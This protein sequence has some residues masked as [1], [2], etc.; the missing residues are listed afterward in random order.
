MRIR[1]VVLASTL[2]LLVVSAEAAGLIARGEGFGGA[3]SA[4]ASGAEGMW[5]NPAVL[6]SQLVFSANAG[7]GLEGGNNALSIMDVARLAATPSSAKTDVVKKIPAAGWDADIRGAGGAAV[8]LSLPV[9]G[10]FGLGV[11]E[12]QIVTAEKISK[13]A[14][15]FALNYSPGNPNASYPPSGK[16]YTAN[17]TYDFTG[18][19]VS[20]SVAEIGLGYSKDVPEPVPGLGLS[21]GASVKYLHGLAYNDASLDQHVTFNSTAPVTGAGVTYRESSKGSGIGVDIGAHAKLFG[22]A[23][24]AIVLKNIG[25]KMTWKTNA[26]AGSLNVN[27]MGFT[28]T[29]AA[30]NRTLTLP[31]DLRVSLAGSIPLVGTSLGVEYDGD[32]TSKRNRVRVGAEQSIFG[33]LTARAGYVTAAGPLDSQVTVGVGVGAIVAGVDLAVG[34]PLG[35][36][37][38]KGGS[39]ALSAYLSF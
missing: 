5:W 22:V 26:Y 38:A 6:G 30:E 18:T 14:V 28:A 33:L 35:G 39:A 32:L 21:A 20:A 2:A 29:K 16:S 37:D 10:T 15:D 12:H 27:T 4:L 9:L 13:D 7:A 17:Q 1:F 36:G 23:K 25:A 34:F 11:F 3:Y 8:A 24:A 19:F 31:L